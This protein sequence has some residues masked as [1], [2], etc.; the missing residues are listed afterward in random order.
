VHRT[1]DEFRAASAASTGLSAAFQPGDALIAVGAYLQRGD[2]PL[3]DELLIEKAARNNA[4]ASPET[5]ALLTGA[6]SLLEWQRSGDQIT[7]DTKGLPQSLA[8]AKSAFE[9]AA[10]DPKLAPMAH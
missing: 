2:H 8:T 10:T 1:Y 9:K 3:K 5:L 4:G 6:A 7:S